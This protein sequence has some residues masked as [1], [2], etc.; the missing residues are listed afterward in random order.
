MHETEGTFGG[1]GTDRTRTEGSQL[2]FDDSQS[3][4]TRHWG[5][6]YLARGTK[7]P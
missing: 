2:W 1:G 7:R 4:L 3:R 5:W 6:R